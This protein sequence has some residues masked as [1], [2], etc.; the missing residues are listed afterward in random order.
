MVWTAFI[1]ACGIIVLLIFA[2]CLYEFYMYL[3]LTPSERFR[4]ALHNAREER[5]YEKQRQA[6]EDDKYSRIRYG[7][8][9]LPPDDY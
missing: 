4:R 6:E 3:T 2:H 9:F 7:R 8:D 5:A 1:I